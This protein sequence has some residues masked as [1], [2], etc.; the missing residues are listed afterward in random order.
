MA[1]SLGVS[2]APR[3]GHDL[4]TLLSVADVNLYQSKM[5]Q[6]ETAD[7]FPDNTTLVEDSEVS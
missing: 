2:Q 5:R 4:M 1:V 7:V 6:P 3:E